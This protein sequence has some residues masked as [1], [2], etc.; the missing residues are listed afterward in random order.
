MQST[1]LKQLVQHNADQLILGLVVD[2]LLHGLD[3]IQL[4][5]PVFAEQLLILHMLKEESICAGSTCSCRTFYHHK[6][7]W[8]R[9]PTPTPNTHT[10]RDTHTKGGGGGGEN[11]KDKKVIKSKCIL[12]PVQY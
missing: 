5:C 1:N 2:E 3:S 8:K 7:E 4:C 9:P 10:Q 12:L 6:E 11:M